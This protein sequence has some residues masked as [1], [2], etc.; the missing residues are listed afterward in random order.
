MDDS[1]TADGV[2]E[3]EPELLSC[4]A[5]TC[6]I[7]QQ[8]LYDFAKSSKTDKLLIPAVNT[9]RSKDLAVYTFWLEPDVEVFDTGC[10]SPVTKHFVQCIFSSGL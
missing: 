2:E 6:N 5:H 3:L 4:E 1:S 8:R 7:F 9:I 10:S